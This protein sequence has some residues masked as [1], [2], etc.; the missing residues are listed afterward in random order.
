M[1]S[2]RHERKNKDTRKVS[3][4]GKARKRKKKKDLTGRVIVVLLLIVT[5][6]SGM[7]MMLSKDRG[8]Q[9]L[10]NLGILR[11]E[12]KTATIGVMGDLLLH[13]PVQEGSRTGTDTYDF[14]PMFKHIKPY[15]EELDYGVINFEGTLSTKAWGYSGYPLFKYP[16]NVIDSTLAAGFDLMLTANNH[17]GDG[18]KKGFQ[19]T[20][21][22]FETKGADYTGSR[23]DKE[24][25]TFLVRDLNGIKVGMANW[26]Y[27]AIAANGRV[28]VNGIPVTNTDEML[29][30]VF[31]YGKLPAFYKKV[32]TDIEA[33]KAE[34]AEVIVYYMHWGNEYKI[35][36]NSYQNKMAQELCNL[37]VDV[38]VGGH[39]HVIQPIEQLTSADGKRQTVCIYSLGNAVSNQQKSRMDL[40]TG[41]TEDGALFR[42]TLTKRGEEPAYVS[43]TSYIPT[44]VNVKTSGGKRRY[45]IIPLDMEKGW[46]DILFTKAEN[47][48]AAKSYARSKAI[49]EPGYKTLTFPIS[50][51]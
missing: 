6:L 40:K 46:K 10:V 21:N 19:N 39:P 33:M 2:E 30:N 36:E 3:Q 1:R 51:E 38:I 28:S 47:D 37:G 26:T 50:E 25:G 13:P 9:Q 49:L 11:V 27:G 8:R 43:G 7:A 45:E 4:D 42:F 18:S 31:D 5:A 23:K 16:E 24:G 17:I 34:G 14:S 15:I 44:W 20:L 29:V 35:Q 12:T 48:A 32:K 22:L 41:H